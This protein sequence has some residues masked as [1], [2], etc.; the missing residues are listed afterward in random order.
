MRDRA[1][2]S[3]YAVA[4]VIFGGLA[5][6]TIV[7]FGRFGEETRRVNHT[8]EVLRQLEMMLGELRDVE[9]GQRGFLIAGD[10]Q[11]LEPYQRASSRV[12]SAIDQLQSLTADNPEQQQHLSELRPLVQEK[13]AFGAETIAVYRGGD[14]AGA[15]SMVRSRRGKLLM[16][17]IRERVRVLSDTE[18]RLLDERSRRAEISAWR[19]NML[20]IFGNAFAF[21]MLALG[22]LLLGRELNRRKRVDQDL[23]F[24]AERAELHATA[25]RAQRHLQTVVSELPLG[26]VLTDLSGAVILDN[27][28]MRELYGGTLPRELGPEGTNFELARADGT[29]YPPGEQPLDRSLTSGEIVRSEEAQLLRA[30]RSIGL[31][32]ASTAP[33]RQADGRIIAAVG[34]FQD[35]A[36]LRQAREERREA[37]QFK[38]LFLGALGH[39]MRN[40][41]TVITTGAASLAR[42]S[43]NSMQAKIASRLASSADRMARMISQLL[44]LVQARLGGGVPVTLE[45]GDLREVARSVIER[46][47]VQFPERTIELITDGNLVG[48]FDRDRIAGVLYDL[49]LNALEHGRHDTPVRVTILALERDATIEVLNQGD[50]IP[51]EM[52]PLV[53]DPFRRAAERKRMKSVGL[54]LGLYLALQTVRAHRG[55]IDVQSSKATG[56]IVRV[57]LPLRT[58]P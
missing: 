50:S 48:R 52:I 3:T 32:L 12:N 27:A 35:A 16:D 26:V 6:V 2:L 9:T 25:E 14:A 41:L 57:L 33:I 38:D 4:L 15:H 17:E 1:I 24:R 37:E 44:D 21:A 13:L 22:T 42:H 18:R 8:Q 45:R 39:D 10:E 40:P 49:V 43:Q 31:V 20:L 11:F 30:D 47:D 29:P 51:A 54:G 56:T 5:I 23:E 7:F 58:E 53:F 55:T 28:R 46:L 36:E 34:I 19:T